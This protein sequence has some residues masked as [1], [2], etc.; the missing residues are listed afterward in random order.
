M[1][2]IRDLE[3]LYDKQELALKSPIEFVEK[4]QSQEDMGFPR[5]QN[6]AEIPDVDWEKYASSINLKLFQ[7]NK[8]KTR[9]GLVA[10]EI[11]SS[12]KF[13]ITLLSKLMLIIL[14]RF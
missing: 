9:A 1:K 11:E 6:V 5:P 12:G 2:A 13:P 4:L 14:S 3:I 7:E 10:N 8:S